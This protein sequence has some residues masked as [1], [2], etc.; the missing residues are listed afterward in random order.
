MPLFVNR[1]RS[2]SATKTLG[3]AVPAASFQTRALTT[4]FLPSG[5]LS[6]FS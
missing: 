5:H 2:M 4:P 3:P 6:P 1:I